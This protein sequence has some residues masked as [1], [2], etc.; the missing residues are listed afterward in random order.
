MSF[1]EKLK[2]GQLYEQKAQD[3]IKNLFKVSIITEQN[4]TNYKNV[5]YDFMTSDMISYEVKADL[6]SSKT[7]NFFIEYRGYNKKSGI[8]IT[9][10]TNHILIN[11]D[12][13]YLILTSKIKE[14]IKTNSYKK[15]STKDGSTFGVLININDI[16]K[17]SI[18]I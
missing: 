14:L 12:K 8:S 15:V 11:N 2:M 6:M 3:K 13:Y 1:K 4:E 7:N 5:F 18:E 16:I 17:F 10:A 9:T